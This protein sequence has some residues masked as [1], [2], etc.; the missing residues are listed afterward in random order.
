MRNMNQTE[1]YFISKANEKA[2]IHCTVNGKKATVIFSEYVAIEN[3]DEFKSVIGSEKIC[4]V[5]FCVW[6]NQNKSYYTNKD[7]SVAYSYVTDK[8][9]GNKIFTTIKA[10]GAFDCELA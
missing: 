4:F 10:N 7:V 9:E 5:T 2:R 1:R 6:N 3:I 8:I